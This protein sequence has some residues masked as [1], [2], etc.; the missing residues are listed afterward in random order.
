LRAVKRITLFSWREIPFPPAKA[1]EVAL[2]EMATPVWIPYSLLMLITAKAVWGALRR[3][4]ADK[5]S[6]WRDAYQLLQ[7]TRNASTLATLKR[8]N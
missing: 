3:H 4:A 7:Q 8:R 1:R 6:K 2:W 5:P